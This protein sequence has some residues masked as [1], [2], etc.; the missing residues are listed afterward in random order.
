MKEYASQLKEEYKDENRYYSEN[1]WPDFTPTQF[2]NLG[3]IILDPERTEK[4]EIHLAELKCS[5]N[6]PEAA[7]KACKTRSTANDS[8]D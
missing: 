6:H 4:E 8:T 1:R 5:G 2:T 7:R 3:F